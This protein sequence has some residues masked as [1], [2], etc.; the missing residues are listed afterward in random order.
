[1]TARFVLVGEPDPEN[2]ESVPSAKLESW[3]ENGVVEWLGKKDDMLAVFSRA[4]MVCLP[5]TYG[6]GVPKVLIEAASCG[7]PIVATD[8]RGCREIVHH[9]ENGFLVP[10][11]DIEALFDA[12]K[13]LLDDSEL[14][15]RMGAR[16]RELAISDFSIEQVTEKTLKLYLKACP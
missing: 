12:I 11:G 9:G 10:P 16:G 14:R 3:H 1:V 15:S 2:S 13:S 7:L 8:V 4:D 5:T 6:E